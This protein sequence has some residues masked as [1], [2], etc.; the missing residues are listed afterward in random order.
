[1]TPSSTRQMLGSASHPVKAL[2][3]E[4]L[5]VARVLVNVIWR[6]VM[7]LRHTDELLAV[8]ARLGR[9]RGGRLQRRRHGLSHERGRERQEKDTQRGCRQKLI[10]ERSA[11]R[12]DT[13]RTWSFVPS[14]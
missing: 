14:D 1:M 3:V 4:D 9:P 10:D 13:T 7:K 2:A 8:W 11:G 5:L 6:W 12:G